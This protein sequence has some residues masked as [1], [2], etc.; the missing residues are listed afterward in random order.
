[1]LAANGNETMWNGTEFGVYG[2]VTNTGE[3]NYMGGVY[4]AKLITTGDGDREINYDQN[5]PCNLHQ[6]YP[7]QVLILT[8]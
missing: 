8:A 1:M 6:A 3:T 4:V 2:C 5:E 7:A